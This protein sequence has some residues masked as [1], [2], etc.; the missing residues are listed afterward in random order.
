MLNKPVLQFVLRLLS[1]QPVLL[2]AAT[3]AFKPLTACLQ[4]LQQ[5]EQFVDKQIGSWWLSP[6][7]SIVTS[8]RE[9]RTL[10]RLHKVPLL[11]YILNPTKEGGSSTRSS[12]SSASS[13]ATQQQQQQDAAA[14][15]AEKELPKEVGSSMFRSYLNE[16]FDGPQ[17]Q[18]ITCAAAHLARQHGPKQ[19][20][21]DEDAQMSDQQ[22]DDDEAS[23]AAAAAGE[24]YVPFTL[25]QGPPGTGKTHTVLGVLNTWH[26]TQFQRFFMS[27]DSA[28]RALAEGGAQLGELSLPNASHAVGS[29]LDV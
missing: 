26:L 3:C 28:V 11:D 21:Q 1:L 29:F 6:A 4:V 12:R 17:I 16:H 24:P 5:L 25:I 27:L 18:A 8:V 20:Q 19:Q 13:D 10:E 7:G 2:C 22:D 15:A 14:A 9:F 23:A